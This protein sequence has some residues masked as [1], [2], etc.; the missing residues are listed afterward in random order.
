MKKAIL[1]LALVG[2]TGAAYADDVQKTQTAT[3]TVETKTEKSHNPITGNNTVTKETTVKNAANKEESTRKTKIKTN[4]AGKII[5][6]TTET[7]E[8]K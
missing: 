7:T 4:E 8:T 6:K 2:L 3:G 5:K 1:V